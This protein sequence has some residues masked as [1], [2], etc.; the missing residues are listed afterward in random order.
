MVVRYRRLKLQFSVTLICLFV[1]FVRVFLPLEILAIIGPNGARKSIMFD[2]LAAR[3]APIADTLFLNSSLLKPSSC[4]NTLHMS[5][6][7]TRAC[8]SSPS[9]RPLNSSPAYFNQKPL[10]YQT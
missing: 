5:L 2:L 8:Q 3:T 1:T 7:T 10:D 6:N 4:G 9:S